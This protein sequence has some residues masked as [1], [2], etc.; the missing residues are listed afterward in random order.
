MKTFRL[1]FLIAGLMAPRL[2]SQQ[3]IEIGSTNDLWDINSGAVVTSHS[4]EAEPYHIENAFGGRLPTV[5]GAQIF[6]HIFTDGRPAGFVHF[7]EWRTPAPVVLRSFNLHSQGDGENVDN[8]REFQS[9]RLL[10]KTA[11]P[12]AGF[13]LIYEFTPSHPYRF[14]NYSQRLILSANV[15]PLLAQEFRA[16]FV[17]RG[18]RFWSGPR[19]MELD[20]FSSMVAAEIRPA[21]ELVWTV[22]PGNRYQVQVTDSLYPGVWSNFAAPIVADSGTY[23][24]FDSTEPGRSRFYRIVQ[25]P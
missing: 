7:V 1:L 11:G 9:F 25:L 20:G 5:F 13:Q 4:G 10:A 19:V 3:I 6:D 21:V 24:H 2:L 8:G 16:E 15:G 14:V 17:D 23:R 18:N 12:T 22:T